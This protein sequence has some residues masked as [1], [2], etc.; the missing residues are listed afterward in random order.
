MA[1]AKVARKST[2]V[3]MTAMC[4]VAFLLLSF[5]ILTTKFKPDEAIAI[6]TPSSVATKPAPEK[7]VITMS[8]DKDGRAFLTFSPDLEDKSR[9]MI[10]VI[11][12]QKNAGLSGGEIESLVRQGTIATPISGLKQQAGIDVK[13]IG[14]LPGVPIKDSANNEM[15]MWIGAYTQVYLGNDRAPSFMFKG[16][17]V[18][19]FPEFKN[20]LKALTDNNQFKFSMVTNPESA[21]QGT[22]LWKKQMQGLA[23]KAGTEE[24]KAQADAD[25]SGMDNNE[26]N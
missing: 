12:T 17:N 11:N 6:Q 13:E 5:F 23:P 21:P 24:A 9:E 10:E 4:D 22:E 25:N 8:L 3:D 14:K 26:K 1:R 15:A 7:N 19:K 2:F 18:A 20:I 16:D